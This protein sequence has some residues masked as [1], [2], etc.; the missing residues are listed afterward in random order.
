MILLKQI[1]CRHERLNPVM[2]VKRARYTQDINSI[3]R[4][5]AI[6][7]CLQREVREPKRPVF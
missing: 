7:L 6:L 3:A 5:F 4:E 2:S 1:T